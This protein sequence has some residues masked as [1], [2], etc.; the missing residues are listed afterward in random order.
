MQFNELSIHRVS[1]EV[2]A[3]V[4]HAV[5]DRYRLRPLAREADSPRGVERSTAH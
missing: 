5:A 2:L 3:L 4:S 1:G